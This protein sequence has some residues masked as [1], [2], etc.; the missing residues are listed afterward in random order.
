MN[1][2][3]PSVRGFF[4]SSLVISSGVYAVSNILNRAVPFFLL[5]IL[6]RFL[7]PADFGRVTMFTVGVDLA[8]PLVGVSTDSAISRRYFERDRIDFSNYLT[9]CGYIL[10]SGTLFVIVLVSCFSGFISSYLTLPTA[11]VF[12]I[13]VVAVGRFVSSTTLVL[14]QAQGMAKSYAMYFLLQT[15]VMF[16]LSICFVIVLD[17]G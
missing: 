10:L 6:T 8:A 4:S 16:G 15:V 17:Y 3:R 11:W 5:P 1:T 9:N 2:L 7:S 14:W 12:T 13:V